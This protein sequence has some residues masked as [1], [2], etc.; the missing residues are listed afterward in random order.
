MEKED[1]IIDLLKESRKSQKEDSN[2]IRD[3]K[4]DIAAMKVDVKANKEDLEEHMLQ[5]RT[6]KELALNI[7][8]EALKERILLK[9]HVNYEISLINKKLSVK[10]LLKLI[11]SGASAI[12]IVLGAA[13]KLMGFF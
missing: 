10:Y 2:D 1:L 6:V 11:V 9:E 7:R 12:S 13:A 8:Q 4:I 3:I 5:T